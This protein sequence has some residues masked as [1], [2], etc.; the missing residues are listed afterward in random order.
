M[1]VDC[2]LPYLWYETINPRN[3]FIKWEVQYET[4]PQSSLSLSTKV[5]LKTN[6]MIGDEIKLYE[7]EIEEYSTRF[8]IECATVLRALY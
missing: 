3:N 5:G 4:S 7:I 1:T 8:G 6:E 2:W